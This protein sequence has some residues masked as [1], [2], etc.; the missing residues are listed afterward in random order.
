MNGAVQQADAADEAGASDGASQL[1]RS[2]RPTC[3]V[4]SVRSAV[5]VAAIVAL[6]FGCGKR[7]RVGVPVAPPPREGRSSL[8]VLSQP[9]ASAFQ[10][11]SEVRLVPVAPGPE[12]QLPEYPADALKASCDRGAVAVRIVISRLGRIV[13]QEAVPGRD[14]GADACSL[15]FSRAVS[16]TVAT[17]GFFPALRETCTLQAGREPICSSQ[18]IDSY[19]DMEFLFEVVDGQTRVYSK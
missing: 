2:V 18:P 8:R 12:N 6:G 9:P 14:A 4:S 3:M 11:Q 7:V 16:T 17:W 15:L 5:L 13:R 1:I 10:G 19:V